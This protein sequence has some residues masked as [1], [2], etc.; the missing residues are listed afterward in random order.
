MGLRRETIYIADI[1]GKLLAI[2][3]KIRRIGAMKRSKNPFVFYSRLH[4][5]EL[6]G[7]IA[8]NI[9]Q[10]LKHMHTV[11]GSCIYQ[12]THHFIQQ[13]QFLSPE[14]P[15]DVGYWI[16]EV[17]GDKYL[18]EEINS[19]DLM[20]HTTIRSIR[21]AMIAKIEEA[22]RERPQ[23]KKLEAPEG[24]GFSFLKSVS[25]AF[26]TEYKA[27]TL[28]QF[29]ECLKKVTLNSIHFHVFEARL[30]IGKQTNDFSL[31]FETSL[32]MKELAEKI[33]NLDPYSQTDERLRQQILARVNAEIE[34]G[35]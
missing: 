1:I 35:K 12:H 17:L 3:R 4:L 34:K 11:S 7:I 20:A 9:P 26:P 14:P 13:R 33:G 32:G 2:H 27:S 18:G 28:K 8:T 6:T 5:I 23:L 31:W 30:R 21:E 19:I 25:F 16:S 10:L 15:N 22:L 29:A 24:Q